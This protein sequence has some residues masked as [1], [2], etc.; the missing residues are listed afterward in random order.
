MH[1]FIKF[2]RRS[3]LMLLL[4]FQAAFLMS[5]CASGQEADETMQTL[6]DADL[7]GGNE[8]AYA[9]VK[10]GAKVEPQEAGNLKS[11]ENK[12]PEK[13][14]PGNKAKEEPQEA[15]VKSPDE[16]KGS[17]AEEPEG[18]AKAE[19]EDEV[20]AELVA[21]LLK[22][23]DKDVSILNDS[24]TSKGCVFDLPEGFEE[25]EDMEGMYVNKHY[26]VD[27]STIYYAEKEEDISMQLMSEKFFVKN[28]QEELKQAYGY[29]VRLNL[30][31]FES[32]E[33]SG[34]PAFRIL[35]NYE[36]EGVDITQLEYIIN[37]D[38]SYV[39]TYSQTGD[40]DRMEEFEQSAATISVRF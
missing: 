25:A 20:K 19:L 11:D 16:N 33:I 9:G 34:Y 2:C 26:P 30:K 1:K 23:R 28:M 13:T 35:Y 27:A 8:E 12:A 6:Y 15:G 17:D 37:A 4:L 10:D 40:Y 18:E 21:Q 3:A 38:K 29:D 39:I 31:S 22:Y 36:C 14:E 5:G 24:R 32:I 7:P